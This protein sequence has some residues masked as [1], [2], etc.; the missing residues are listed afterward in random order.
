MQ[1]DNTNLTPSR[2]QSLSHVGFCMSQLSCHTTLGGERFWENHQP[3][4]AQR[5]LPTMGLALNL[6]LGSLDSLG[7]LST[8]Y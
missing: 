6:E 1:K 5:H 2:F 3:D 7:L 8:T 4:M